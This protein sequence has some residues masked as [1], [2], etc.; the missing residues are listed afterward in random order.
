MPLSQNTY[1]ILKSNTSCGI[2]WP[3]RR[4]RVFLNVLIHISSTIITHQLLLA[5]GLWTSYSYTFLNDE[6]IVL[7]CSSRGSDC[8]SY[9]CS[10]ICV[11]RVG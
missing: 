4:D 2:E 10:H 5:P 1:R 3:P 6:I 9:R 8:T 11:E 7:E